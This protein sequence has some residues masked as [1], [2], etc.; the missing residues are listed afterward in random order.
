L[1]VA[2]GKANVGVGVIVSVGVMVRVC[3]MV[4]VGVSVGA[5]V[6]SGVSVSDAVAVEGNAV[7]VAST[8]GAGLQ[9]DIRRTDTTNEMIMGACITVRFD[10]SISSGRRCAAA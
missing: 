3:V 1:T 6:G 9:A 5:K 4:G 2:V 7:S 8:V 10:P